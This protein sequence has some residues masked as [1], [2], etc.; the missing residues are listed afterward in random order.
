M[1]GILLKLCRLCGNC[2][3]HK[4]DILDSNPRANF[5]LPSRIALSE[6]VFTLAGV[7][8]SEIDMYTAEYFSRWSRAP[9]RRF[10]NIFKFQVKR[11]GGMTTKICE[12]CFTKIKDFV[13]FREICMATDIHLRT[14]LGL[15]NDS[16][17]VD[18]SDAQPVSAPG[19]SNK[20]LNSCAG[21]SP[22]SERVPATKCRHNDTGSIETEW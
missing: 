20:F 21:N 19:T 17:D 3:H 5:N 4:I 9:G 16:G 14:I 18:V 11:Y 6:S 12:N 7:R 15:D 13:Q 2:G 10:S 8:V 1:A 22:L